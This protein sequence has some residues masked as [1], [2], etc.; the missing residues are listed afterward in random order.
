MTWAEVNRESVLKSGKLTQT[1]TLDQLQ[2]IPENRLTTP[3]ND[4]HKGQTQWALESH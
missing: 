1:M 2:I 4:T 3:M